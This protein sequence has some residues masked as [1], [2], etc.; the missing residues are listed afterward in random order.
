MAPLRTLLSIM[1]RH[2]LSVFL[3]CDS[4]TRCN[5][6][7]PISGVGGELGGALPTG[8]TAPPI[9]TLE[10]FTGK[11]SHA[12]PALPAVDNKEGKVDG[13]F[14]L[15]V[16]YCYYTFLDLMLFTFVRTKTEDF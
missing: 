6:V 9:S 16:F 5:P 4:L 10:S 7:A 13:G 1:S 12:H 3:V 14:F 2:L 8:F 11:T 15:F